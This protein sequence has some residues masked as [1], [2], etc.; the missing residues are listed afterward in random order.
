MLSRSSVVAP[1]AVL[2]V[3]VT[4]QN[5]SAA[6]N[7][8]INQVPT[9]AKVDTPIPFN[10]SIGWNR[11]DERSGRFLVWTMWLKRGTTKYAYDDVKA[12]DGDMLKVAA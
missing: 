7:G 6:K 11:K 1:L 3:A 10:V 4:S 12:Q 8:V 5:A 9:D 2:A